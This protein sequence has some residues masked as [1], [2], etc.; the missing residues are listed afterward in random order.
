MLRD[1]LTEAIA[2]RCWKIT[3]ERDNMVIINVL[4]GTIYIP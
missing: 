3:I 2:A 4:K 1:G